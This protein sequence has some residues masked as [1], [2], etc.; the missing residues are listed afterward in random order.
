[1]TTLRSFKY[2]AIRAAKYLNQYA[3]ESDT[4]YRLGRDELLFDTDKLLEIPVYLYLFNQKDAVSAHKAFMHILLNNYA[5]VQNM[6]VDSKNKI[7]D[8]TDIVKVISEISDDAY[9]RAVFVAIDKKIAKNIVSQN[10]ENTLWTKLV[11]NEVETTELETPQGP[12]FVLFVLVVDKRSK[13]W[14]SGIPQSSTSADDS[15]AQTRKCTERP[16]SIRP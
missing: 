6:L 7:Y 16:R 10:L 3:I 8:G 1:M 14:T 11:I 15:V 5:T 12:I 13:R 4:K 2:A 9:Q